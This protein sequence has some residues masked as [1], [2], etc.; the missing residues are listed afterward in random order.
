[1]RLKRKYS[2]IHNTF[3]QMVYQRMKPFWE[4]NDLCYLFCSLRSSTNKK[5]GNLFLHNIDGLTIEEF[6]FTNRRW[7]KKKKVTLSELE[8]AIIML[9][10]QGKNSKDISNYLLKGY[11]TIRNQMKPL[12]YK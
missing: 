6:N 9:Y 2:F 11:H 1:M 3:P 7:K 10:Q 5:T 4:N 12:F 8:R